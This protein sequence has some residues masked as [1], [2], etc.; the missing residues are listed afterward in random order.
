MAPELASIAAAR[1]ALHQ[2]SGRYCER[3]QRALRSRG[4]AALRLESNLRYDTA[5]FPLAAALRAL[6]ALPPAADLARLHLHLPA[7]RRGCAADRA[8]KLALLRPLTDCGARE[9]FQRLFDGFVLAVVAPEVA[10]VMTAEGDRA[11]AGETAAGEGAGASAAPCNA[12]VYQCFPCVRLNRPG[13]FSIGPHVDSQYQLPLG[14][15][16]YY[17]PLVPIWGANSLFRESSPGRCL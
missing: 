3:V 13:E 4:H 2:H 8:R 15:V 16:N 10:R 1:E 11:D 7:G 14:A 6:L 12:V 5:R 9:E 17:V